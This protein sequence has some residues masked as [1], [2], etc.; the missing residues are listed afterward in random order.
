MSWKGYFFFVA[1]LE[2]KTHILYRFITHRVKYF[3]FLFF[4]KFDDQPVVILGG[5]GSSGHSESSLEDQKEPSPAG[6][7]SISEKACRQG[8]GARVLSWICVDFRERSGPTP[9]ADLA[10]DPDWDRLNTQETF[11]GRLLGWHRDFNLFQVTD[12]LGFHYL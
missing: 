1:Y 2:R 4:W 5:N 7:W 12:F 8:G 6:D 11:A 9:G 10:P 3:K